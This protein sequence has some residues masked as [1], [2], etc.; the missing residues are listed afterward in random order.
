MAGQKRRKLIG[1]LSAVAMIGVAI[2]NAQQ[3]RA[4]INWVRVGSAFNNGVVAILDQDNEDAVRY[5]A[6]AITI[7]PTFTPA[8]EQ[9][10]IAYVALENYDAAIA[11]ATYVLKQ[12][13]GND[14]AYLILGNAFLGLG[15]YSNAASYYSEALTVSSDLAEAYLG[16][17]IAY[18]KQQ[19]YWRA[20][21][22]FN[23]ALEID[24]TLVAAYWGR[25]FVYTHLMGIQKAQ[26]D[27]IKVLPHLDD[28]IT[29]SL[30]P[31]HE[32]VY[33][34]LSLAR[35]TQTNQW[36]R[37][38]TLQ[39]IE[40]AIQLNAEYP[41]AYL[42]RGTIYTEQGE[43]QRAFDDLDLALGYAD[44]AMPGI[45]IL[46]DRDESTQII[47]V[48]GILE[49][50]QSSFELLQV[51]DRIVAIDGRPVRDMDFASIRQHLSGP[52]DT[53]VQLQI[54]RDDQGELEIQVT[55]KIGINN[56][57]LA[58]V[59]GSRA[60]AH[61]G[62]GDTQQAIAD[63]DQVRQIPS[64]NAFAY[65]A[66]APIRLSSG[67]QEGAIADYRQAITLYTMQGN[68]GSVERV[69]TLLQSLE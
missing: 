8:Y 20:L 65:E 60:M 64:T 14:T 12:S 31:D 48:K 5:F 46:F 10:G 24:P 25:G 33:L 54:E 21:A 3:I 27:F 35:Y 4:F 69:E 42:F 44:N 36:Q 45:G 55:R 47:V 59:F 40:Q 22:D 53:Q 16:R 50:S 37:E 66:C 1:S 38:R 15:H 9:R 26:D 13:E 32:S 52:I 11:D 57:I 68:D 23:Q 19:D 34:G 18:Y 61:Q 51:G 49:A 43:H 17:G 41:E 63:C 29:S 62:L 28:L 6:S 56:T 7:D 30:E 67:D 58:G 2:A 39:L